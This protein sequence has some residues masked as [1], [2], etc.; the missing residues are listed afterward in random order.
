MVSSTYSQ[1]RDSCLATFIEV[2]PLF[3]LVED[4]DYVLNKSDMDLTIRGTGIH[5]RSAEIKNKLRG[6]NCHDI[7]IDEAR[8]MRDDEVFLI[9][10]GRMRMSSDGQCFLCTTPRGKDWVYKLGS[11]EFCDLITQKTEENPFLPKSYI[12]DLRRRYTSQYAK[13]ELDAEII[14][15]SAGVIRS[16]WF[17]EVPYI[18]PMVGVRGWDLAVSIKTHA[19]FAAGVLLFNSGS[20]ICIGNIV[21]GRF[22]Y[23]DLR[24]KI[25]ETAQYD[26][27]GVHIILEDAG[28]QRG[29]IDDLKALPELRGYVIKAIRPR[30]DKLTRALPI[31]SRAE[32]GGVTVCKG[33]WNDAFYDECDAFTADMTHDHDDMIDGMSMSYQALTE[34]VGSSSNVKLY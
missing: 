3:G 28:Q 20:S 1:L 31:V 34:P 7:L 12:E 21:H 22:E 13:Q 19:D 2:L 15:M 8:N 23:P 33:S 30:S 17:I 4:V 10:I 5:M 27:R 9:L 18:K 14:E 25:V 26:G 16:Q 11:D 6:I 29:Y 24:K 32:M